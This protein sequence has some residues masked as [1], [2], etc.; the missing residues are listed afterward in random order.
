M[1]FTNKG[2]EEL[3]KHIRDEVSPETPTNLS[4][5]GSDNTYTGTEETLNNEF[6]RK[7]VIWTQT[8]INSKFNVQLVSTEAIGSSIQ[9]LALVG[10]SDIGS[11]ILFTI[12]QSFIGTKT[13]AFNVQVEG[14]LIIRRPSV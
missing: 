14:E 5:A 13:S 2:I 4:F 10:G 3:G 8:G 11:D 9:T 7:E 12:N 6:I 1:T